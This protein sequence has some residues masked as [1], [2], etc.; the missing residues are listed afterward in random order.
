MSRVC[1]ISSSTRLSGIQWHLKTLIIMIHHYTHATLEGGLHT[2]RPPQSRYLQRRTYFQSDLF[3]DNEMLNMTTLRLV[4][5]E[6]SSDDYVSPHNHH[7]CSEIYFRAVFR[8][9][10]K[11]FPTEHD[12]ELQNLMQ[13][14]LASRIG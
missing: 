12:N 14:K 8:S 13:S 7:F 10:I 2:K 5:F 1:R 4:A 6:A 11:S 3:R 9:F